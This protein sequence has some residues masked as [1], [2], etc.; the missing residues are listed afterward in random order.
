MPNIFIT[1]RRP[2][3]G[4]DTRSRKRCA[5]IICEAES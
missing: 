3:D 4:F 5:N 1:N 2:I